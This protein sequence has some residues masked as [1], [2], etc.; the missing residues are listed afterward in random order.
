M[1]HVV[2]DVVFG[3]RPKEWM[4]NGAFADFARNVG[5]AVSPV[6]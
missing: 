4:E 5:F 2:N 1:N 3:L 6:H